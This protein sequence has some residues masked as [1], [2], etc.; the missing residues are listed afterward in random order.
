M[1]NFD[2]EIV[3]DVFN[4]ILRSIL[5]IWNIINRLKNIKMIC[6]PSQASDHTLCPVL[7]LFLLST[8]SKPSESTAF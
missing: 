1:L 2:I 7:I 6:A 8:L 5:I 3:K 4:I